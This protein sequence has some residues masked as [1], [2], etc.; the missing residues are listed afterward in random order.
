MLFSKQDLSPII[1]GLRLISICQIQ[2]QSMEHVPNYMKNIKNAVNNIRKWE[3][4]GCHCK[5]FLHCISC[6]GYQRRIHP[7]YGCTEMTYILGQ[8]YKIKGRN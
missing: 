2:I 6:V 3:L 7:E 1:L 8:S 5:L 4:A